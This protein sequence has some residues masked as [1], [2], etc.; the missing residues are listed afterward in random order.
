MAHSE[1]LGTVHEVDLQMAR[2]RYRERGEGPP[3][4]FG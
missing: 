1:A 2:I 4:L 3:V